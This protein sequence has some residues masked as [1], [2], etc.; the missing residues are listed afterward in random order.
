MAWLH[1]REEGVHP[2]GWQCF[3]SRMK[4][5]T[6][7]G[8]LQ[9]HVSRHNHRNEDEE[10]SLSVDCTRISF[11]YEYPCCSGRPSTGSTP[12]LSFAQPHTTLSPLQAQP[13]SPWG[14]CGCCCKVA[15]LDCTA[16]STVYPG[17]QWMKQE[18]LRKGPWCALQAGQSTR[19]W[20]ADSVLALLYGF[21][22]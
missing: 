2:G 14:W 11:E 4:Y 19:Y 8:I 3:H 20:G 18:A 9:R 5:V 6:D 10:N 13:T 21:G 17:R 22:S 15:G 7:V 1:V 16:V 12:A